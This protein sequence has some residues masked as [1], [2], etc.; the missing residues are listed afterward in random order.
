MDTKRIIIYRIVLSAMSV[1]LM[2]FMVEMFLRLSSPPS[3]QDALGDRSAVYYHSDGERDHPWS[4][5]I[6]A[7]NVL[8]FAVVGDSFSWAQ[9]VQFNDRYA[10]RLEELLNLRAGMPPAEVRVYAECGTSTFQQIRLVEQALKE[11]AQFVILGI[12]VND[13][14]DWTNPKELQHWRSR[15]LPF[16]PPRPVARVLRCSRALTWLYT[17]LQLMGAHKAEFRYYRHIYDPSYSGVKR[18]RESMQIINDKCREA[19]AVFIPMIWPLLSDD[20]NE[21]RYPFEYAHAAIRARC[22]E[23]HIPCLDLLPAFRHAEPNRLQVIPELDPH[24]NEIA[25]RMAAEALLRFLLEN[26]IIPAGYQPSERA[27]EMVQ[28]HKWERMFQRMRNPLREE[29]DSRKTG[30]PH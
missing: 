24:P 1:V 7:T 22:E 10:N 2:L 29:D 15:L 5:G 16:I 4:L 27:S 25:H 28:R 3:S 8:R 6:G 14:E 12:C 18:F 21:G 26:K 17:E 23:L 30:T 19:H 11:K 13:M 9:G 20:L